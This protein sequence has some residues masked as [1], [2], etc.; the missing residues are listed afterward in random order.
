MLGWV[1]GANDFDVMINSSCLAF[2]FE[3]RRVAE[4][5]G[6]LTVLFERREGYKKRLKELQEKVRNQYTCQFDDETS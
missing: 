4:A 1:G 5:H 6:K 2:P 3:Q